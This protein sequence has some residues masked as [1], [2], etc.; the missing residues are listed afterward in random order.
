MSDDAAPV[1][2]E[3]EV[4]ADAPAEEPVGLLHGV[5]VSESRGQVVLH[6]DRAGYRALIEQLRREGYWV[7]VDLCAVDYL[8]TPGRRGLPA[9][10]APE[11]FEVVVN[12]LD[13]RERRRIRVRVQ[14]PAADA[15]V[16]SLFDVH[17]GL[18]ASERETHDLMGIVFE[19]HPDLSRILLPDD[20]EGHPLRKDEAIGRIPVQFSSGAPR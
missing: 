2:G 13:H 9:S 11:R 3:D 5:P 4:T 16:P 20:W 10:V 8:Q 1:D 15:T 6:P 12:L 7:A 19:G 14:V 17:P 18:E